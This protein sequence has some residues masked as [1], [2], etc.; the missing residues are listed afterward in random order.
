MNQRKYITGGIAAFLIASLSLFLAACPTEADEE[1]GDLT[2]VTFSLEG[3][4][5]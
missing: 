3:R 1:E 4:G 2:S 5:R